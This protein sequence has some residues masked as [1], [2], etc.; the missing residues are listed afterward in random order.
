MACS[1]LHI[2]QEPALRMEERDGTYPG[3]IPTQKG[4]IARAPPA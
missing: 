3:L 4:I 2:I 1:G